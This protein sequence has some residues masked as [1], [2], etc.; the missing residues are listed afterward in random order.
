MPTTDELLAI[1][2][3]AEWSGD[4][5]RCPWCG[6][7]DFSTLHFQSGDIRAHEE[8]CPLV[9]LGIDEKPLQGPERRPPP[10]DPNARPVN[11]SALMEVALGYARS[12]NEQVLIE[13]LRQS[14]FVIRYRRGLPGVDEF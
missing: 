12:A 13:S 2:K 14:P 1:I 8:H 9:R 7:S 10:R 3:A 6:A 4:C 5:E 11:L